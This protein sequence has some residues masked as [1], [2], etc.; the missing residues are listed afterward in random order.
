MPKGK[1]NIGAAVAEAPDSKKKSLLPIPDG[2][3]GTISETRFWPYIES[4]TPEDWSHCFGYLYGDWPIADHFLP[5]PDEKS[6]RKEGVVKYLERLSG[7]FDR[8]TVLHRRGSGKYHI[9]LNDTNKNHDATVCTCYLTINDERFPPQR[10]PATIVIGHPDNKSYVAQLRREG[11]LP[12][13]GGQ[14]SPQNDS[15]TA[16]ALAGALQQ[17]VRAVTDKKPDSLDERVFPQLLDMMKTASNKA[18]EMAVGQVKQD[19]PEG[20]LKLIAAIKELMPQASSGDRFFEMMLKM[21][22]DHQKLATELQAKNTELLMRLIEQKTE[23]RE[24]GENALVQK[25]LAAA[26]DRLMNGEGGGAAEGGGLTSGIASILHEVNSGLGQLLPMFMRP[27]PGMRFAP[28]PPGANPAEAPAAGLPPGVDENNPMIQMLNAITPALLSHLRDPKLTGEDFAD[29]FINGIQGVPPPAC[30]GYGTMA[31]QQVTSIGKDQL[32]ATIRAYPALWAQIAPVGEERI[33]QF[34]E[35]FFTWD[36]DDDVPD[37]PPLT[38]G[39]PQIVKP[40][41]KNRKEKTK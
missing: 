22:A 2:G 18:I 1:P 20:I 39:I 10:D 6:A 16:Q 17:L 3:G 23:N 31:Y 38:P 25:V 19:S 33:N 29:W 12:P 21:Q 35:E 27:Q 26:V 4:L 13:E 37:E 14:M 32:L 9:D 28:P 24:S 11:K 7:P 36:S 30:G 40:E 15:A 8:D 34:L 5:Y 41:K